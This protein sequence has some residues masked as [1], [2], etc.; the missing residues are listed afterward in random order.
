MTFSNLLMNYTST[1]IFIKASL[2]A[3]KDITISHEMK[4]IGKKG[5]RLQRQCFHCKHGPERACLLT[6][7]CKLPLHY[8][9]LPNMPPKLSKTCFK[10][11]LISGMP[12]MIIIV[13][14]NNL[15]WQER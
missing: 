14:K 11:H 3:A 15:T 1:I 13:A 7:A 9:W 12:K 8:V 2:E 5:E 6:L 4:E 10:D